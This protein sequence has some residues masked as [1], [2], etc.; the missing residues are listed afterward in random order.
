VIERKIDLDYLDKIERLLEAIIAVNI[1]KN[2]FNLLDTILIKMMDIS[3][4]DAGTLYIIEDNKLH[5]RIMRNITLNIHQ[6]AYDKIDLPPI[7]LDPDNITNVCAYAAIKNEPFAIDDV[8]T[9]T[10]FDFTG[11][12]KYDKITGYRT[13]SMLSLPLTA[14]ENEMP[15]V[16]GVIQLLNSTDIETGIVKPFEDIDDPPLLPSLASISANALANLLHAQ[17]IKDLFNS[18]VK[19]MTKAIDERSPFNVNHTKNVAIYAERFIGYLNSR[20]SPGHE[21]YFNQNRKDQLVMAC[22]LHDIGKII[23]PLAVMDKP[24]RLGSQM[25][26][27]KYRFVI[28]RYQIVNDYLTGKLSAEQHETDLKELADALALIDSVNTPG[29]LSDEKLEQ[30]KKLADITYIDENGEITP[31]LTPENMDA[32]TIRKGTLT[33]NE[34]EIMHEHVSVTSRL[35]SEMKFNQYY[36]DVRH[37]AECH[38]EFLNGTGYPRK[39]K[40]SE[41]T[42]E[43]C[44]LTMI[45]IYEALTAR[46][47]PYKPMMPVDKALDI[48]L[49]DAA[50]GKLHKELVELFIESKVWEI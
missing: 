37:W 7:V 48:L 10:V 34:I 14:T 47:R 43:I 21:F 4:A 8:Y 1:E 38:H 33:H 6:S 26:I 27:V 46:D 24:D 30:V 42:T 22:L 19:V 11:P 50:D 13:Q 25:E 3:D 5:F 32:L 17:E 20:F 44:I 41:V 29:F 35:L 31:V 39:L 36:K 28:K 23:T 18:F 49:S 15:K 45:D 12:K 40:G 9:S 16:I 2:Y